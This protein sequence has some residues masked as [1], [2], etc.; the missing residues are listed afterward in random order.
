MPTTDIR[1]IEQDLSAADL[2]L[3]ARSD[4]SL[5][6][7]ARGVSGAAAGS[8]IEEYVREELMFAFPA[9]EGDE[10]ILREATVQTMHTDFTR[11][12]DEHG[13]RAPNLVVPE[14]QTYNLTS[15]T[16]SGSATLLYR[17]RSPG[18]VN[19][20]QP[21]AP[22]TKTRSFASSGEVTQSIAAGASETFPV[23]E[24]VQPAQL[25]DFPFSQDCPPNREYDMQAMMIGL[26]ADSGA[27][28]TLDGVRLTSE[29]T[30]FLA[31]D[32]QFVDPALMQYPNAALTVLP[33]TFPDVPTFSP[34]EDLDIAVSAANGGSGAEDATVH[35]TVLFYRRSV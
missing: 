11:W 13:F 3:E 8:I 9:D 26:S 14:G 23:E 4:E 28:V 16:G 35:T 22:A 20:S 5:E 32:S 17:E 27:N 30:D 2:E 25:D 6:I 18:T 34:G 31:R 29:G 33:M 21:G 19:D 15:T 12:L 7:V 24:S 1:V 10:N